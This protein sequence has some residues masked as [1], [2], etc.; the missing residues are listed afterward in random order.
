MVTII[1]LFGMAGAI[2]LIVAWIPELIEIIKSKRSKLDK[3]FSSLLLIATII[4]FIYSV[5]I[6]DNVFTFINAF[7]MFEIGISFYYSV[8]RK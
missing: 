3:R 1:E 2:L 6:N 8:L 5:L 7:L 4:L